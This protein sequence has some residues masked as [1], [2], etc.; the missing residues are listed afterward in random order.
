MTCSTS[1]TYKDETAP[2]LVELGKVDGKVYGRLHQGR[3]QGPDLVQPQ[4]PRLRRR[5]RRRPGPT[6]SDPGR[7]PTRAMPRRSGASGIESGAASGWPGT[8]WIEDIVLRTGRPG[9]VQPAGT[10]ASVK[11]T[12]P[13]DQDRVQMY[14]DDVVANTVRRRA[15]PSWRPTS[16][17]PATRSS[18]PARLRRSSTRRASSPASA[19]FKTRQAG[20]DYN[21]F[22]FPDI[23]P[24]YAG[25][26]EGAGDLFGMFH[27]TADG[28]VADEVPGHRRGAGHLGQDRRRPV[29][30]QERDQLPGRHQQAVGARS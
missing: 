6:C 18:P 22:P 12:R 15:R 2:A 1:P 17:S 21:F 13:G 16:R 5:P 26:V 30:Q 27:D 4:A 23:D 7:R 19:Q 28:Q 14:V 24:Q 20:T 10:R 29:G 8:D 25:A 9:E 3:R 11:W